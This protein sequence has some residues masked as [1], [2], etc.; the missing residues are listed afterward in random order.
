MNDLERINEPA[1]F[2][3]LSSRIEL[4][5]DTAILKTNVHTRGVGSRP[6]IELQLTDHPLSHEQRNGIT[7]DRIRQIAE[8]IEHS[9]KHPL[10][11][12]GQF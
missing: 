9:W 6:F 5:P 7:T 11:N 8:Q 1:Y 12:A 3:W 4:Y 2:G 10:W